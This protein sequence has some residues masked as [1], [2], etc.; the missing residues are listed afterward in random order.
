MT[1][2]DVNIEEQKIGQYFCAEVLIKDL[3]SGKARQFHNLLQLQISANSFTK[4][5]F[6]ASGHYIVP[7][8]SYFGY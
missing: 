3:N 1:E 6:S 5:N 2:N 8:K 7:L 4:K